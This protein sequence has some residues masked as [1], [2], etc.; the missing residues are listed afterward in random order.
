MTKLTNAERRS[1]TGFDVRGLNGYRVVPDGF[2]GFELLITG[3]VAFS[4]NSQTDKHDIAD[5]RD[6][7]SWSVHQTAKA[8]VAKAHWHHRWVQNHLAEMAA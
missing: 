2:G 1:K 6:N 4:Y 5:K 7:W 3:I 8:A